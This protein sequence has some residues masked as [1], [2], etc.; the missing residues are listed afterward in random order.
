MQVAAIVLAAGLSR[1]AGDENKLLRPWGDNCLVTHTVDQIAH[2]KVDQVIVVTGHQSTEV[3]RVL[4]ASGKTEIVFNPDYE[5]G[6][7]QSIATGV[8][9]IRSGTS[10]CLICLGDM[11]FLTTADYDFILETLKEK[12]AVGV[13]CIIQPRY[14]N[15]PGHP[16]GFSAHFFQELKSLPRRDTGAK[17]ILS[18]NSDAIVE[19]PV[20]SDHFVHDIDI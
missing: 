14:G 9:S 13:K 20:S 2:S 17:S 10:G 4:S 6:I 12:M 11:P 19:L 7:N 8:S 5:T 1:R 18:K 3:G 15:V 16:V